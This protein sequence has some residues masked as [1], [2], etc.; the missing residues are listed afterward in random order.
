MLVESRLSTSTAAGKIPGIEE[1][2]MIASTAGRSKSTASPPMVKST[3][4]TCSGIR[5]RRSI[6]L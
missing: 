1:A 2:T 4:I 6:L 5:L 3:A